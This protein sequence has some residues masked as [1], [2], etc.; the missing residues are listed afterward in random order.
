MPAWSRQC[1]TQPTTSSAEQVCQ[2]MRASRNL[3]NQL[4]S[5]L[6]RG[7]LSKAPKVQ[8]LGT[9]NRPEPADDSA[10]TPLSV[11]PHAFQRWHSA[12][13]RKPSTL[14]VMSS[15][16]PQLCNIFCLPGNQ[17]CLCDHDCCKGEADSGVLPWPICT[18][19]SR[20]DLAAAQCRCLSCRLAKVQPCAPEARELCQH[21]LR[22]PQNLLLSSGNQVLLHK[23]RNARARPCF[24]FTTPRSTSQE[25]SSALTCVTKYG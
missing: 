7:S 4:L 5:V 3:E 8:S 20:Y 23:H 1:E 16:E 12:I 2:Q 13:P 18:R 22:A 9:L 15:M 19:D 21:D 24:P 25:C 10:A 17:V 11:G 6:Q 14:E